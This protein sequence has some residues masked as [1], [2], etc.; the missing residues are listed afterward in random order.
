MT[1]INVLPPV[2][3]MEHRFEINGIDLEKQYSVVFDEQVYKE[4]GKPAGFKEGV[5]ND[6][7]G[8]HG[9]ERL[10][11]SRMLKS[12]QL[13]LPVSVVGDGLRDIILKQQDFMDWLRNLGYFDLKVYAVN[14]IYRL[15]YS[16]TAD[17]TINDG[18]S[19]LKLICF[20]DEPHLTRR[21]A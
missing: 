1:A 16:D 11:S 14:R 18:F 10:L 12:R 4:L 15:L 9:T 7:P 2:C 13:V 3:D 19:S 8:E 6:W 17:Y 21:I 20:D 5:L